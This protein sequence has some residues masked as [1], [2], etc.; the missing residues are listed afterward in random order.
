M[1]QHRRRRCAL[2]LGMTLLCVETGLAQTVPQTLTI[3]GNFIGRAFVAPGDPLEFTLS[4]AMLPGEG[5]LAV[6]IGRMDVTN[7]LTE[8]A[9]G[10]RY[11]PS[12]V[13]LPLG[14]TD[15]VVYRI[16]PGDVWQELARFPVQ[17]SVSETSTQAPNPP[18]TQN[19]VP[20]PPSSS[21]TAK[22]EKTTFQGKPTLTLGL[23]SHAAETH[24]PDAS[25]PPQPSAADYTLQGNLQSSWQSPRVSVQNQFDVAGSSVQNQALRF[26]LRGQDAPKVD[27]SNY[28]MA[29]QVGRATLQAGQM[30][31][32][33]HRHLIN[34]FP[35]RGVSLT[36][37]VQR[38]V[39]VTL[40]AL[41]GTN[42]VGWDNFFGLST[43][44]HRMVF[45]TL[46]LELIP[47]RPGGL[48]FEATL[49]DGS[50][51]PIQGF[52]Q[53]VVNDASKSRGKG[54]RL[55]ASDKRQ[56]VRVDGGYSRSR[57]HNPSDPLL[58][59]GQNVVPVLEDSGDARY[60]D[61][62]WNIVQNKAVSKTKA[63]N[64]SA[65]YRHEHVDPLYRSLGATTQADRLQNQLDVTSTVGPINI[66][67]THM[68]GHNNLLALPGLLTVDTRRNALVLAIPTASLLAK[69]PSKPSQWLPTIS[70]NLDQVHQAGRGFPS[71]GFLNLTQVPDQMSTNQNA[72]VDWQLGRY[73][74]AYR[75]NRSFQDNRQVGR[76]LADLLN[77]VNGFSLGGALRKNLDLGYDQTIESAH[78]VEQQRIDRL[79]RSGVNLNWRMTKDSVL[80]A[81]VSG[82]LA[83]DVQQTSER[84][85]AE[86]DC[87]WSYRLAYD[88]GNI[89]K[90]QSQL[91]VRYA[92][93][94]ASTIDNL[95]GVRGL[96]KIQTLN[97]GV[98]VTFF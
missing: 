51:Q 29:F 10:F 41:N 2:I 70:Y 80:T 93:R 21:S 45:G 38:R 28:S 6:M 39:S 74:A 24:F 86:V 50:V 8:T 7:L 25:Q 82:T 66:L 43:Q 11:L 32:G 18:P 78:N 57:F 12:P 31:F 72:S 27:L 13:A 88:K 5:K 96:T 54:V 56:R 20:Q 40:G 37:P 3:S 46:G 36:V 16:T 53:G 95:F 91:L 65:T 59:Q 22:P 9:T 63:L 52:N 84:R 26:G 60:L 73:R 61:A 34:V 90:V 79:Y 77:M 55:V 69:D 75:V 42:I 71:I 89:R 4:R 83:G 19:A 14:V 48:R 47:T 67:L 94:Y 58:E 17:V 97:V 76:E 1:N 85:N 35:S 15:V 68:L 87:Q 62:T 30:P 81:L 23:T 98:S 33:T 49:M 64:L 92:N 44:D